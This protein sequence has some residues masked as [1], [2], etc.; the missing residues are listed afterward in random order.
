MYKSA[1]ISELVELAH[2]FADTIIIDWNEFKN[3]NTVIG[4]LI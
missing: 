4:K 1:K 2:Q 3:L